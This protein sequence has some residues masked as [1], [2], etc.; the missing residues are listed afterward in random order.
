MS[1]VARC[2]RDHVIAPMPRAA[3][4]IPASK[5]VR[6]SPQR[7]TAR[8]GGNVSS[9][10]KCGQSPGKDQE[11]GSRFVCHRHKQER[12]REI[13]KNQAKPSIHLP[14]SRPGVFDRAKVC[15]RPHR[16]SESRSGSAGHGNL[17]DGV[18][19]QKCRT[20]HLAS[21]PRCGALN[22]PYHQRRSRPGRI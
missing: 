21:R 20:A 4:L 22:S 1:S 17:I 5:V 19:I 9:T 15:L 11:D 13:F 12:E 2:E 8:W 18:R 7:M 6:S 3:Y 14:K 16:V 10:F